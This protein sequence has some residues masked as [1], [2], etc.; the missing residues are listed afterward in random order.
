MDAGPFRKGT[1]HKSAYKLDGNTLTLAFV[2]DGAAKRP[3]KFE[4]VKG[5]KITLFTFERKKK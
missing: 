4:S 2:E 5:S 3:P 1:V